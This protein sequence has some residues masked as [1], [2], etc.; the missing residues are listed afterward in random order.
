MA[1]AE[2]NRRI[3]SIADQGRNPVPQKIRFTTWT[4]KYNQMLW[5]TVDSLE[6]H[7]ERA[8][9]EAEWDASSGSIQVATTNVS[10]LS[11]SF[12]PGLYPLDTTRAP[13][14]LLDGQKLE[15]AKPL[16]DR[17]W[18]SHFQKKSGAWLA[19]T[20]VDLQQE[21]LRKRHDLQGPIDDAFMD[22]FIMVRPTGSALNEKVGAW[23]AAELAHATNHWRQQFRG[24]PRVKDD[25]EISAEEIDS[26]NLVLWGDPASNKLLRQIAN[27]LPIHWNESEINLGKKTFSST[28]HVPVLIYPNPLNPRRYIVLNSG[29]TFREYDYLN[30]ARQ[31][32]KLPDYAIID[33]DVPVSS[34]APGAVTSAGFFTEQWELRDSAN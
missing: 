20:P 24:E 2:V 26:S 25:A 5:L 12:A 17:S 13:K 28:H 21:P 29:F 33:V 15:G 19:I 9:V 32:P 30:N 34:R 16:S 10:A 27:K 1:K 7:W 23:A 14:V 22:S 3:N 6:E 31:T 11:F 8:R 18:T 4:L